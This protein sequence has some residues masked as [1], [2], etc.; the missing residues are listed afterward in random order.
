MSILTTVADASTIVLAVRAIAGLGRFREFRVSNYQL[1][2]Q[3]IDSCVELPIDQIL[4]AWLP[5]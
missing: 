1:M 4:A 3:L 2:L 5:A